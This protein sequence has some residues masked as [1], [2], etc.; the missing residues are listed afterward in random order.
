M[1]SQQTATTSGPCPPA[2]ALADPL[3]FKKIPLKFLDLVTDAYVYPLALAFNEFP[4][5][6]RK[7][8]KFPANF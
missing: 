8:S 1:M 6:S 2:R 5:F 7:F 4:G 3:H